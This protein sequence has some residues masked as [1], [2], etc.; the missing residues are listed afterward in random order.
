MGYGIDK[1]VDFR[2]IL[3]MLNYLVILLHLLV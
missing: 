2:Q 3:W 1:Y